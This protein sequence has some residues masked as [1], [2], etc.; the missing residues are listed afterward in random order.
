MNN[1]L[2]QGAI[3]CTIGCLATSLA[4]VHWRLVDSVITIKMSLNMTNVPTGAKLPTVESHCLSPT[5]GFIPQSTVPF[6]C[7][8][9]SYPSLPDA[10]P[11]TPPALSLL[12]QKSST[13][14]Q[15][16]HPYCVPSTLCKPLYH[17]LTPFIHPSL[18]Q[19]LTTTTIHKAKS[20]SLISPR[21][22]QRQYPATVCS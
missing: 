3:L 21:E 15:C 10:F 13:C 19:P 8:T 4:F 9:F 17:H 22:H 7:M 5:L 18:Q 6:F 12:S 11:V 16:H 2:L 14:S 1:F 20:F